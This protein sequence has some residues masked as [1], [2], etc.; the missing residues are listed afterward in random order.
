MTLKPPFKGGGYSPPPLEGSHNKKL[1]KKI[2]NKTCF[3]G[4]P[5]L[6]GRWLEPALPRRGVPG[7]W[8]VVHG[9]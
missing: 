2:E 9:L 4:E 8:V 1:K 6:P 3:P 7:R 5:A